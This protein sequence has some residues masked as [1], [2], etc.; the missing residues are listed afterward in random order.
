LAAFRTNGERDYIMKATHRPDVLCWSSFDAARNMDFN[1][2]VWVNPGGNV[3]VDPL[4]MAKHD[5][6][7]LRQLGAVDWIVITNSDHVR[8]GFN[9]ARELGAP[10]AGP[11]AEKDAFPLDCQ[12][13]L[14]E[15]DALVPGM[16]VLTMDGSK[17]PGELALLLGED[18]LI[19]GDLIRAGVGGRLAML[20]DAKLRDRAAARGSVERILGLEGLDA[21]LVGDGWP[22][23]RDAKVL[24][25]ELLA[26]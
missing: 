26:A 22:V 1:S 3:V 25:G 10:L 13:W 14:K 21:I 2:Y 19:V 6:A 12:R 4:P 15:G 20:P 18:T 11:A 24:L 16:R 9:M 23:F 5:R 7:Q 8:D 17:T